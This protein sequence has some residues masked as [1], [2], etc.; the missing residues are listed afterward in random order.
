MTAGVLT[1]PSA[2]LAAAAQ[3]CLGVAGLLADVAVAAALE[4]EGWAG[5]GALADGS[6]RAGLVNALRRRQD[7]VTGVSTAMRVLALAVDEAQAQ[8]ATGKGL[9]ATAGLLLDDDGAPQPVRITIEPGVDLHAA[10]VGRAQVLAARAQLAAA[11]AAVARTLGELLQPATFSG[12]AIGA[13]ALEAAA[14]A[15]APPGA[16]ASSLA[17]ASWWAGLLGLQR[18]ALLRRMP[19]ALGRLNGL[20]AGVRDAANRTLLA[21]ALGTI[22]GRLGR[23]QALLGPGPARGPLEAERLH[24]RTRRAVLVGVQAAIAPA[25]RTLLF[26]DPRGDGRAEVAVGDVEHAHALGLLVPGMSNELDELPGVVTDAA[27]VQRAAGAGSAVVAWLGY[28][29]PRAS[30]VASPDRAVNGAALLDADVRGL[31]AARFALADA[32]AERPRVTVVGHSYGSVLTGVAASRGAPVD[33]V[34]VV[35]SPGIGSRRAGDLPQGAAHVW[36]ARAASDPIRFV[37]DVHRFGGVPGH[38]PTQHSWFGPDPAQRAFGGQRFLVGA[39]V[40]GHVRYFEP[41]TTSVANIGRVVAGRYSDVK[42]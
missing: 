6:A 11:D 40:T 38:L 5:A 10:G 7:V 31:R 17:V 39:G 22:D 34:V 30:Q 32:P 19:E 28:D 18:A 29:T 27:T 35:G 4:P 12:N 37:F 15:P 33:D 13:A 1:V 25:G 41:G 2:P 3:V 20:P 23:L 14:S 9:A 16:D 26:L 8:V 36:A 42:R 21:N 24:L